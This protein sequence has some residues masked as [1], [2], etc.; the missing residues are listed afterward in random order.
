MEKTC[1]T[2]LYYDECKEEC[3]YCHAVHQTQECEDYCI[4]INIDLIKAISAAISIMA[5]VGA[6]IFLLYLAIGA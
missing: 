4:V 1:K 6:F 3:E 5:V 2:C